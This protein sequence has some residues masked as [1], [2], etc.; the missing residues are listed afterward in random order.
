MSRQIQTT[1]QS[2]FNASF[3]ES[4]ELSIY[5]ASLSDYNSGILHGRWISC[6][7]GSDFIQDQIN[8]MLAESPAAQKYNEIAEEWAIHDY[9][10]YGV[11]LDESEDLE[12]LTELADALQE[13]GESLAVYLET[14][15][16][17]EF[18]GFEDAF[19]GIYDSEEA[20]AQELTDEMMP[21]DAPSFLTQYFDYEAFSR[22]LFM[23]DNFS[24]RVSGGVAVFRNI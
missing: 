1:E 24:C 22:D 2:T 7:K 4:T 19:C 6:L 16:T 20:Y 17:R 9:D 10:F 8:E 3:I 13:H 11:S 15:G 23:S 21:H 18:S 12:Q 5:V 14:L